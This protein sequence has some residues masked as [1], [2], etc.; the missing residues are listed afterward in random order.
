MCELLNQ[1]GQLCNVLLIGR[2]LLLHGLQALL[3]C[4]LTALAASLQVASN[5]SKF[6]QDKT[7]VMHKQ[8]CVK[9]TGMQ[10]MHM[11]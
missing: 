4:C 2:K 10:S 1:H 11:Q 8:H 3:P 7:V 5:R 6:K 9:L